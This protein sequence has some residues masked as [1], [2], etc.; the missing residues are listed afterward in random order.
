MCV[1]MDDDDGDVVGGE[2]ESSKI[3]N[4]DNFFI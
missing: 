4:I 2:H 3:I 1:M